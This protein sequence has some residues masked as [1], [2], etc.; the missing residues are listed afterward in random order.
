MFSIDNFAIGC[1]AITSLEY[2]PPDDVHPSTGYVPNEWEGDQWKE[3][4][5]GLRDI[6]GPVMCTVNKYQKK[7]KEVLLKQRFKVIGTV[8]SLEGNGTIWILARGI[9]APKSPRKKRGKHA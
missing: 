2:L 1:C 4:T 8:K 6:R 5:R 7:A 9:N 3:F